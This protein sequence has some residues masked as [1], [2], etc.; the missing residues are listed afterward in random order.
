MKCKKRECMEQ[1]QPCLA[2][3][4]RCCLLAFPTL[5]LC[6]FARPPSDGWQTHSSTGCSGLA[7]PLAQVHPLT[8]ASSPKVI[9]SVLCLLPRRVPDGRQLQHSRLH[10]GKFYATLKLF[11]SYYYHSYCSERVPSKGRC[12]R[13]RK[14]IRCFPCLVV[15]AESI[16]SSTGT[17]MKYSFQQNGPNGF[18]RTRS[19]LLLIQL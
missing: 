17:C 14:N 2:K 7:W 11:L 5:W 4:E 1:R 8:E 13:L 15:F 9:R 19:N 6:A 3:S 10:H 18:C 12:V 16:P